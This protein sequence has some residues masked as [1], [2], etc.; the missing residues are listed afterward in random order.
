LAVARSRSEHCYTDN[1]EKLRKSKKV[2][3]PLVPKT[4]ASRSIFVV[5]PHKHGCLVEQF[6][7]SDV[8]VMK[9]SNVTNNENQNTAIFF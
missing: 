9:Y 3:I 4:N 6:V 5:L 2:F 7:R 8:F 1:I